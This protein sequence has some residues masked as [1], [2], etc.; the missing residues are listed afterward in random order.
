M[1]HF[2]TCLKHIPQNEHKT[3]GKRYASQINL[4]MEELN[5]RFALS[6][7]EELQF[8]LIEDPFSV[9]P[10]EL[11]IILQLEVIELQ[12]SVF[13]K[14]KHRESSLQDLYKEFNR[15]CNENVLHIW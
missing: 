7:D 3:L 9:N 1:G 8:R 13:Y 11:P 6:K 15:S 12:F 2:L 5:K 14:S 4:L 10:E